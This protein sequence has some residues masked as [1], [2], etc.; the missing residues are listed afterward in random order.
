MR[1]VTVREARQHISELLDAVERGEEVVIERRGHP[2]ARLVPVRSGGFLS[3]ADLRAS[4]PSARTPSVEVVR[5]L[6]DEERS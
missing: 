6:R 3:R 4:L 2:A 1:R 5:A